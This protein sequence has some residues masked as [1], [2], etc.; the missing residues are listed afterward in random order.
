MRLCLTFCPG[1]R[2]S[3]SKNFK[4]LKGH[5]SVAIYSPTT[6]QPKPRRPN[7][8]FMIAQIQAQLAKAIPDKMLKK[9]PFPSTSNKGFAI[10]VP[11]APNT[12]RNKLFIATADELLPG[13]ASIRYVVTVAKTNII[14]N[15]NKNCPISG[16][17]T[18]KPFS[19]VQPYI[20]IPRGY[21]IAPT[22]VDR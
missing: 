1:Y 22:Q 17:T 15:P 16:M 21:I 20:N 12:H 9:T 4:N 8:T 10:T 6:S 3:I 14:P 11:I 13:T 19:T 7:L 2:S 18:N 5:A